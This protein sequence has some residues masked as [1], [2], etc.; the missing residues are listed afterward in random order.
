MDDFE[1]FGRMFIE[2]PFQLFHAPSGKRQAFSGR[3]GAVAVVMIQIDNGLEFGNALFGI[4]LGQP[5]GFEIGTLDRA[6]IIGCG[7]SLDAK[8]E[9]SL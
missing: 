8:I 9:F 4:I 3:A 6:K 1:L 2:F 7:Q 5:D